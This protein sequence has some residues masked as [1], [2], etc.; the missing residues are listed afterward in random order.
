MNFS[1]K[2]VIV[3]GATRGIGRAIASAFL[4]QGAEVIAVYGGNR[5]AALAFQQAAVMA[6]VSFSIAIFH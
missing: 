1:G 6:F 2:K 4:D 3:T 5:E